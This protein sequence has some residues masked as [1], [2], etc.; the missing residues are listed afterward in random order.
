[1]IQTIQR[2]RRGFCT[3]T[4]REEHRLR[5][6]EIRAQKSIFGSKREDWTGLEE[7]AQ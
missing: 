4:V 1:M 7:A 3:F 6:I 5:V 2:T